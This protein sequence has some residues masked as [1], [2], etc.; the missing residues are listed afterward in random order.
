MAKRCL[1]IVLDADRLYVVQMDRTRDHTTLQRSFSAPLQQAQDPAAIKKLLRQ[2]HITAR[3]A[4]VSI[5]S[6]QVHFL[7]RPATQPASSTEPLTEHLPAPIDQLLTAHHTNRNNRQHQP[8]NALAHAKTLLDRTT[9]LKNAALRCQRFEPA[10]FALWASVAANHP[11]LLNQTAII[12]YQD[13]KHLLILITENGNL[14]TIRDIPNPPDCNQTIEHPSN[15]EATLFHEIDL[16]ARAAL[17]QQIPEKTT[18]LLAGDIQNNQQLRN[19]LQHQFNGHILC[20]DPYAHILTNEQP[21]RQAPFI[22]AT[23]LALKALMPNLTATPTFQLN[24][25]NTPAPAPVR[26][27]QLV[28]SGSLTALLAALCV[29][30]LLVQQ[31]RLEKHAHQIDAQ[32]QQAFFHALPNETTLVKPLVQ[33]DNHLAPLQQ[34]CN[35]LAHAAAPTIDPLLVLQNLAQHTPD[36]LHIQLEKLHLTADNAQLTATAPSYTALAQWQDTLAQLPAFKTVQPLDQ[37]NQYLPEQQR[38]R[39]TLQ[40]T[41]NKE[42]SS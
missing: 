12:L 27:R 32:I 24:D 21:P 16:T 25:K 23:G 3:T 4:A 31:N 2:H 19:R 36:H 38:V 29:T 41:F 17:G 11:A 22:I 5:P 14:K 10:P 8:L 7:S 6:N 39:F 33:L 35:Q 42:A 20:H 34:T 13:T 28:L 37:N 18:L 26:K 1:G 40:L 15:S 9:L 30:G